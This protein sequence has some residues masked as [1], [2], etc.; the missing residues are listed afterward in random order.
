MRVTTPAQSVQCEHLNIKNEIIDTPEL[1]GAAS[2]SI[3]SPGILPRQKA[4]VD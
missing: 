2:T 4:Q 3:R 1:R